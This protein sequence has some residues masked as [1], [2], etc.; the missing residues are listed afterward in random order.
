MTSDKLSL[1]TNLY[2]LTTDKC[3]AAGMCIKQL[4]NL[5]LEITKYAHTINYII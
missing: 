1:N 3:N 2:K 5:L 4:T